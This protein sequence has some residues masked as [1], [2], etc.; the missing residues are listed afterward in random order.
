MFCAESA[1]L[2]LVSAAMF[3]PVNEGLIRVK[4]FSAELTAMGQV[5]ALFRAHQ[6]G[7]LLKGDPPREARAVDACASLSADGKRVV[8]TLLNRACDEPR[9]VIV[10]LRHGQAARAV[11]TILSVKEL[12]PDA[13]MGRRVEDL[14]VDEQGRI[15]L[16]LPRFGIA[17]MDIALADHARHGARAP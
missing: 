3:Q 2:D 8:L 6:G 7:R 5:F 9:S 10:S 16:R 14:S 11:A 17:L 15:G 1:S 4:P 13:V 12:Q